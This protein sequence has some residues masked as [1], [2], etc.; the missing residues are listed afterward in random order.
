MTAESRRSLETSE[1]PDVV[2]EEEEEGDDEEERNEGM[3]E[4]NV[5]GFPELV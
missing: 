2:V 1:G 5:L 3:M 4:L